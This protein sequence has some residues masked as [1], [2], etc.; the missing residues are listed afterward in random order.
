MFEH[1]FP[2]GN[3][4]LTEPPRIGAV[5]PRRMRFE[6]DLFAR[7]AATPRLSVGPA[8]TEQEANNHEDHSTGRS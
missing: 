2:V 8:R 5:Q 6:T 3:L 1:A 4:A 7:A